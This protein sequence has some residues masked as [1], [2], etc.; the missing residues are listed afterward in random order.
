VGPCQL[1]RLRFQHSL[2][3]R[4]DF[5]RESRM[6]TLEIEIDRVQVEVILTDTWNHTHKGSFTLVM[7]EKTAR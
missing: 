2:A 3:A 1:L 5:H 7:P 6:V 4:S